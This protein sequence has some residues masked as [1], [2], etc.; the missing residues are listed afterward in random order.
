MANK[1]TFDF[2]GAMLDLAS[3]VEA[4]TRLMAG[5][6][7][8][9][10][11][12][13]SLKGFQDHYANFRREV[14]EGE[15]GVAN[16]I[17]QASGHAVQLARRLLDV[18]ALNESLRQ[19]FKKLAEKAEQLMFRAQTSEVF[20]VPLAA[21]SNMPSGTDAEIKPEFAAHD[22]HRRELERQV[23][24]IRQEIAAAELRLAEL[25][26]EGDAL[27]KRVTDQITQAAAAYESGTK[28]V[29]K[30]Q[31]DF[32]ELIG[33]ATGNVIHGDY[34]ESAKREKNAADRTR[35]WALACMAAV[36]IGLGYTLFATNLDEMKWQSA[37]TRGLLALAVSIPAGYLARESLRHRTQQ[38]CYLQTAL[39]LKAMEP[40]IASLP[41][42]ERNALKS[43]MA[44]RLFST[45]RHPPSEDLGLLNVHDLLLQAIKQLGAAKSK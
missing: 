31:E 38:H 19:E 13:E 26:N 34:S 14:D 1:G 20:F 15:P 3:R 30:A 21:S 45:N 44:Q 10:A 32:N 11:T 17:L 29:E 4:A 23:D 41:E 27:G 7:V 12:Q 28:L 6:S 16:S 42:P 36:A 25:R 37:V 35:L 24:A 18:P 43:E 2:H 40:F 5:V 22:A 33:V 39:N 9:F 8:P